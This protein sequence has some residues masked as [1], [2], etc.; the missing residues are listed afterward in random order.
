MDKEPHL[1]VGGKG[2]LAEGARIEGGYADWP[3]FLSKQKVSV[4]KTKG[5]ETLT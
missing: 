2:E 4:I 1:D 5:V 3:P